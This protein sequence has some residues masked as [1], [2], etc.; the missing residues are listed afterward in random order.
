MVLTPKEELPH[1]ESAVVYRL[2]PS[3][4]RPPTRPYVPWATPAFGAKKKGPGY[5]GALRTVMCEKGK[6]S[7]DV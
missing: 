4:V 5:T 6:E 3:L 2:R 7:S 1:G